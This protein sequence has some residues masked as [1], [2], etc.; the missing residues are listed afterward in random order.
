MIGVVVPLIFTVIALL[1]PARGVQALLIAG[2][3]AIGGLVAVYFFLGVGSDGSI[4]EY[5]GTTIE[6]LA[7]ATLNQSTWYF[8]TALPLVLGFAAF[9]AAL[10]RAIQ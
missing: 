8:F 4:T 1:A 9:M 5:A 7:S 10:Y 2:L 3:T 6:Y